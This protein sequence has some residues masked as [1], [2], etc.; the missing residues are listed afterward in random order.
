MVVKNARPEIKNVVVFAL[1]KKEHETLQFLG[2]PSI[3]DNQEFHVGAAEF[4]QKGYD[5]IVYK[6]LHILLQ[7]LKLGYNALLSDVD[8]VWLRNPFL[9]IETLPECMLYFYCDTDPVQIPSCTELNTGMLFVRSNPKTI[10]LVEKV[11]KAPRVGHDQDT[12]NSILRQFPKK[13]A[14]PLFGQCSSLG[15]I[16]YQHLSLPE[17]LF[18]GFR[19]FFGGPQERGFPKKKLSDHS[20]QQPFGIHFNWLGNYAQKKREMVELNLWRDDFKPVKKP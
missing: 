9:F 5:D 15:E 13:L 3:F 14:D 18:G 1:D 7:T 11:I 17:F 20:F 16:T 4:R 8:V 6:K 12:F 2:V 10:D 19:R